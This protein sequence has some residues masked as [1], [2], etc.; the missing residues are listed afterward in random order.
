MVSIKNRNML[1]NLCSSTQT[2]VLYDCLSIVCKSSFQG[3][4]LN[5]HFQGKMTLHHLF[6]HIWEEA[7][8]A[9]WKLHIYW[10]KISLVPHKR[11][12]ILYYI[13]VRV[14][15]QN[16]CMWYFCLWRWTA[17]V[18]VV[19]WL[20]DRTRQLLRKIG[21]ERTWE[22]KTCGR[23]HEKRSHVRREKWK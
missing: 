16:C 2:N 18:I 9:I 3:F 17:A 19:A 23:G 11:L 22:K 4:G 20:S 10:A 14:W 8:W 1:V 15:L 21:W 5:I 12:W 13:C 7:N 6:C